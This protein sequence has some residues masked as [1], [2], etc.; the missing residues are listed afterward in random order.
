MSKAKRN[1]L[2]ADYEGM[3]WAS[4]LTAECGFF[5]R[6]VFSV[7]FCATHLALHHRRNKSGV[8]EL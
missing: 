6:R 3:R 1:C 4:V 7:V 5:Q 8:I 2:E